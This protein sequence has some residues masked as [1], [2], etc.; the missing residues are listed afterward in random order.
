MTLRDWVVL[1]LWAVAI[2]GVWSFLL[3]EATA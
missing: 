3:L 1:S 2:A